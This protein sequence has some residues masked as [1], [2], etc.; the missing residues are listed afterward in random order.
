M[1]VVVENGA[2][3]DTWDTSS[4]IRIYISSLGLQGTRSNDHISHVFYY[5]YI[6]GHNNHMQ[7]LET[8]IKQSQRTHLLNK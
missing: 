5:F 3:Y 7:N 2:V 8:I 6:Y 4:R 1:S